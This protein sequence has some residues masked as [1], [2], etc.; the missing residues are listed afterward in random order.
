L[1]ALFL[2]LDLSAVGATQADAVPN[3]TRF[4]TNDCVR[5]PLAEFAV[6]QEVTPSSVNWQVSEDGLTWSDIGS[7]SLSGNKIFLNL[8]VLDPGIRSKASIR[9]AFQYRSVLGAWSSGPWGPP[10]SLPSSIVWTNSQVCLDR[11]SAEAAAARIALLPGEPRVGSVVYFDNSTINFSLLPPTKP[12]KVSSYEYEISFDGRAW[13]TTEPMVVSQAGSGTPKSIIP[14]EV[15]WLLKVSNPESN[16]NIAF[17]RVRALNDN[18]QGSWV[19]VETGR[20]QGDSKVV[21]ERKF[22]ASGFALFTNPIAMPGAIASS[23]LPVK[24]CTYSSME[25]S[26][27]SAGEILTGDTFSI[28]TSLEER[29]YAPNLAIQLDGQRGPRT[30]QAWKTKVDVEQVALR[31]QLCPSDVKEFRPRYLRVKITNS[32]TQSFIEG[33]VPVLDRT[34]PLGTAIESTKLVCGIANY[35]SNSQPRFSHNV[36]I[37]QPIIQTA[38]KGTGSIR[39]TLFRS[40]LVAANQEFQI[41]R[42]AGTKFELVKRS[43]TDANG[44]FQVEFN[45]PK[46]ASG[47]HNLFLVVQESATG[48]GLLSEAFAAIEVQIPF[49]WSSKGLR[50]QGQT[51]DWIPTQD[52][53]CGEGITG[54]SNSEEGERHPVAWFIAKKIYYGMKDKPSRTTQQ[55]TTT[56]SGPS[57]GTAP[58]GPRSCWVNGYTTKNGKRV[59]GYWRSC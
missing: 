36:L 48:A 52:P 35:T 16:R 28:S 20:P 45:F 19:L 15:P 5:E 7:T 47:S 49:T 29:E 30:V 59:S 41:L 40:G 38:A 9:L 37:D 17:L 12:G 27:L 58:S 2:S 21:I 50:Y 26:E 31:I 6:P 57:Y 24:G 53:K 43:R 8:A 32:R 18:G 1:A 22:A 39:G 11:R 46:S 25:L 13:Q 55:R 3:F 23:A 54:L 56:P 51:T 4:D 10:L 42:Q 14:R 34:D 33:R 44:Q